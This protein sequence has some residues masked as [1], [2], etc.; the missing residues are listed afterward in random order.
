MWGSLGKRNFK[1]KNISVVRVKSLVISFED[2]I[3]QQDKEIFME[4]IR[5]ITFIL[6]YFNIYPMYLDSLLFTLVFN[7]YQY[8]KSILFFHQNNSTI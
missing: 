6:F 3:D 5:V 4:N 2:I 8:L 1:I 7:S